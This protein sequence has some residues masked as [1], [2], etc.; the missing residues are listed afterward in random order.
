[1]QIYFS[2]FILQLINEKNSEN[3]DKKEGFLENM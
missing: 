1:M 3:I 2:P